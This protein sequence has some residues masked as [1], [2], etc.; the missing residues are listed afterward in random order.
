VD[1]TWLTEIQGVLPQPDVT[2]LLDIEPATALA[3]KQVGRD[4]YERDLELLARVRES[5]RRQA[6]ASSSWTL[7][8]GGQ[9]KEAVAAEIRHAVSSRLGLL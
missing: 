5:Y 1:P 2:I 9:S 7:I 3:R 4:R 6:A 8:N